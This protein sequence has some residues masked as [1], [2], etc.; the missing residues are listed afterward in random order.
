MIAFAAVLGLAALAAVFLAGGPR[1]M[2]R[3]AALLYGALAASLA[4]SI[5]PMEVA[6]IVTTLAV[7]L[8]ALAAC[9]ALRRSPPP[10]LAALLASAAFGMGVGAAA[11]GDMAWAIVPQLA[12]LIIVL[13]LARRRLLRA[14]GIYLALG[15]LCLLAAASSLAAADLR[16]AL[17]LFSSAGLL[18]FVLALSRGSQAFVE[19]R[20]TS[21]RADAIRRSR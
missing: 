5:A 17:P 19:P 1:G 9:Q 14:P 8:L 13:M 15:A 2:L 3:F 18:G 20:R 7:A 11:S 21:Q 4:F 16:V 12:S 10:V 6:P